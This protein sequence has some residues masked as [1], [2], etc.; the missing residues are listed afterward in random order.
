MGSNCDQTCQFTAITNS[1]AIFLASVS[2]LKEW[3]SENAVPMPI[4]SLPQYAEDIVPKD[5]VALDQNDPLQ[6]AIVNI[7]TIACCNGSF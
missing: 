5:V 2:T 1:G 3:S 6:Q 7:F 4:P